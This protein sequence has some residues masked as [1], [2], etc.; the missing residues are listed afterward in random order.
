MV[1]E[2]IRT[3]MLKESSFNTGT[4]DINY[5]EGSPSG[6]PLVLLHGLPGRWQEFLP[7]IPNL[8]LFWHTY[9]LDFRG[10]TVH[11]TG[12]T[13]EEGKAAV[14]LPGTIHQTSDEVTRLG[15]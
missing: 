14:N 3:Q 12:G 6:P 10:A 8:S 1:A 5:A 15:G 2:R 4:V 7:I 9:A 13:V 11:I